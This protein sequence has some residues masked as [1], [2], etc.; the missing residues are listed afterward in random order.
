ME[1]VNT[2]SEKSETSMSNNYIN[3][4]IKNPKYIIFYKGKEVR[5]FAF[6]RQARQ[7]C[8]KHNG[9]IFGDDQCELVNAETGET[10]NNLFE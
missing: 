7:F 8:I 5:R 9:R 6:Y 10:I 2:Q 3:E 4:R 1:Q